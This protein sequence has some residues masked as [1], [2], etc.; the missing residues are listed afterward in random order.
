MRSE[1]L[2]TDL[3][4]MVSLVETGILVVNQPPKPCYSPTA[5][6]LPFAGL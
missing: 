6:A 1:K 3:D 4:A 5:L 2:I